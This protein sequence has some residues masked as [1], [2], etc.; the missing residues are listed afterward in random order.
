MKGP[1]RPDKAIF[2]PPQEAK[3]EPEQ[4]A[5]C[6]CPFAKDSETSMFVR[7][8]DLIDLGDKF[9]AAVVPIGELMLL[10]R[11][12]NEVQ[13]ETNHCVKRTSR[14]QAKHGLLLLIVT[15]GLITVAIVQVHAS[16]LQNRTNARQEESMELNAQTRKELEAVAKELRGLVSLAKKTKEKVEDIKEEQE[17]ESSVQLVAETDPV[18]AKKAPVKVR[19]IPRRPRK[20]SSGKESAPP[21]QSAVEL[22]IHSKALK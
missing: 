15:V 5:P 3:K 9:A 2:Q 21:A 18:K 1:P 4:D 13:R 12:Q 10:M 7:R 19:I 17:G 14:Q 11:E 20:V 6:L 22:P 16:I 8:Q